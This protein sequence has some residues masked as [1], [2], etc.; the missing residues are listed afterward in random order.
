MKKPYAL[1]LDE[2]TLNAIRRIAKAEDRSVNYIIERAC[3]QFVKAHKE[4]KP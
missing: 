4:G 1:R 3:G 2:K